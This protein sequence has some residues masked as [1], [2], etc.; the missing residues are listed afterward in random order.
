M[1]VKLKKFEG[2]GVWLWG[3]NSLRGRAL[4]C[5]VGTVVQVSLGIR[6]K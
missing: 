3:G 2:Q 5:G 6:Y 1:N 4:G